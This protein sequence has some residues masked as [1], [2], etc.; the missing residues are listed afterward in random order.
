MLVSQLSPRVTNCQ[1]C[2]QYWVRTC[3]PVAFFLSNS[4]Q[5]GLNCNVFLKL[6]LLLECV[7]APDN[8]T[9]WQKLFPV[10]KCVLSACNRGGKK[11]KRNQDQRLAERFDRWNG[12]EFG[13]FWSK[14]VS[15]KQSKRQRTNRF[16]EISIRAKTFCLQGQLGRAAKVLASE[17]LEPDNKATFKTHGKVATER[18]VTC[19]QFTWRYWVQCV[20]IY[21][22]RSLW[23]TEDIHQAHCIRS[24]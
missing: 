12:G 18:T 3:P 1:R 14:A 24:L 7:E 11:E 23:K 9:N 19:C 22:K 20:P 8:E 15:L 17:G 10:W 13:K 16:E 5:D 21:W 2:W 4:E 6:Q